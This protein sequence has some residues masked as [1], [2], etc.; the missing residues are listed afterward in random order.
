MIEGDRRLIRFKNGGAGR[1]ARRMQEALAR[2]NATSQDAQLRPVYVDPQPG[3]AEA[4]ARDGHAIGMSAEYQEGTIQMALREGDDDPVVLNLDH[5]RTL[6]EC[7]EATGERPTLAY[8]LIVSP[9]A[10]LYGVR[11]LLTP[12]DHEDRRLAVRLF[13]SLAAVTAN[14]GAEAVFGLGRPPELAWQ[15]PAYRTWFAEHMT[16]HAHR[17]VAGVAREAAAIEITLDG[18]TAMPLIIA[19]ATEWQHPATLANRVVSDPLYPIRR[20]QNFAVAEVLPQALRI[21]P[22]RVRHTDGDIAVHHAV[23]IDPETTLTDQEEGLR[24]RQAETLLRRAQ[25]DTMTRRD[26]ALMTD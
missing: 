13:E 24:L 3:K 11:M 25:R 19:E 20:G 1:G 7:L 9:M 10:R 23:G 5:P 8:T 15:E 22:V 16:K 14:T 2:Y 21:H 17:V 6:A 12:E 18:R 4:L 26:A